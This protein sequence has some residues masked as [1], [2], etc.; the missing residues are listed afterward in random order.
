MGPLLENSRPQGKWL[1]P[2]N[3]DPVV[4]VCWPHGIAVKTQTVT[5]YLLRPMLDKSLT[6]LMSSSED[7][8]VALPNYV[9]R[10]Q[11]V[12]NFIPLREQLREQH[13]SGEPHKQAL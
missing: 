1:E 3:Y 6:L 2:A 4:K 12:I 10:G 5:F 11:Q 8:S 9:M 13:H 7:S